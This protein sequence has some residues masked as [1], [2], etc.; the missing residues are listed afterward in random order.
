[1]EFRGFYGMWY[2]NYRHQGLNFSRDIVN[3][4]PHARADFI[5]LLLDRQYD[6]ERTAITS[7]Q[8]LDLLM[9]NLMAGEIG[10]E[11]GGLYYRS[12]SDF[13]NRI[14][15]YSDANRNF[16]GSFFNLDGTPATRPANAMAVVE[17]YTMRGYAINPVTG[18]WTDLRNIAVY[19]ITALEDGEFE[20]AYAG[21]VIVRDLSAGDQVIR[22]YIPAS[23]IPL[24][25]VTPVVD[26]E[27]ILVPNEPPKIEEASPLRLMYSVGLNR[28]RILAG[29]SGEYRADLINQAGTNTYHF[30]TNSWW[31]QTGFSNCTIAFFRANE[32]NP[33][34]NHIRIG[35]RQG[36]SDNVTGT[37][38]FVWESNSFEL[39]NKVI[40]VYQ[41]GNNGRMTIPFTS[42]TAEKVWELPCEDSFDYVGVDWIKPE[43]V[44]LFG[45]EHPAGVPNP[46][47]IPRLLDPGATEELTAESANPSVKVIWDTIPLFDLVPNEMGNATRVEYTVL[48]GTFTNNVLFTPYG[49]DNEPNPFFQ[50]SHTQPEWNDEIGVWEAAKILNFVQY[51]YFTVT[52]VCEHHTSGEVPRDDVKYQ[53]DEKVTVLDSGSLVRGGYRFIGWSTNRDGTGDIFVPGDTFDM[54][55]HNVILY[56]QW[57]PNLDYSVTYVCEYH[58]DGEVPRDDRRYKPG[59]E[60]IVLDSGSL[61][62]EGYRFLGWST[63]RDGTGDIFVQGDTFDMPEHNVILYAQWEPEDD[64]PTDPDYSVTYVC[65]HHTDGE[66]PRDE[67]RYQPDD[68]VVVL[69]SGSLVR[70]GYRFIGWSTSRDGTGDTF[71]PG[72]TFDMPEHNVILYAQWEPLEPDPDYSVTYVCEH[73]TGGE[74]PRDENRY[75]PGDEVVVLDSGSL[76]RSGYRFIGWNTS[77]DGTG[78][79]FVPGDTFDMPASDVILYAQ[80]EPIRTTP[81]F[82]PTPRPDPTPDPTPEPEPEPEPEPLLQRQAYLIGMPSGEIRPEGDIT[83]AEIATIFFRLVSDDLREIYWSQEHPYDDVH[84]TNWYNNAVGKTTKMGLFQGVSEGLFAPDQPITRAELAAVMVRFYADESIASYSEID[85]MFNDIDGHWARAYINFAA[86]RNWIQGPTGLSGPFQPNQPVTRA[87]TAAMINRTFNRLVEHPDDLHSDMITWPDN[88]NEDRWYYLYVQSATNSYTYEWKACG[89][90]KYWLEIIEPRDWAVLERPTS[91]PEDIFRTGLPLRI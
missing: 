5:R 44:Q 24:R 90:F 52:Y 37:A 35:E 62:R 56:A 83:R 77:R 79:T 11:Y 10:S 80:W 78:D 34:Y 57:E 85:D 86:S 54:P 89:V 39:E 49:P 14:L 84:L 22:W 21:G 55:E 2:Q 75:Q 91:R 73:H 1:M 88:Q 7:G 27:G 50:I 51:V 76:V 87:E 16:V 61:V 69:D 72:D 60:V 67:N 23:L 53:P 45:N 3:D 68:E 31:E 38:N 47:G 30:Y 9:S 59:E 46:L 32:A 63:S 66:V 36:K 70:S 4:E 82:T 17:L 74:V 28:D 64:P 33:F 8:A 71:V 19:V 40:H 65:E 12:D 6:T 25:K 29:I 41:L 26:G 58:T 42:L 13:S 43:W 15:Y 18:M 81:N 20:C 48:E